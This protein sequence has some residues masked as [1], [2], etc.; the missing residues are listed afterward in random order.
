MPSVIAVYS[1]C[2]MMTYPPYSVKAFKELIGANPN[3]TINF[4][5]IFINAIDC[6]NFFERM[7]ICSQIITLLFLIKAQGV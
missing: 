4:L 2:P 6:I 7:S 3:S 1:T 5:L